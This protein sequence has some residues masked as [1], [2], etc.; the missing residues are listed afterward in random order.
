MIL[1][2]SRDP[3][4]R[5]RANRSQVLEAGTRL[6]REDLS[7]D[8]KRFIALLL[9][10]PLFDIVVLVGIS[11]IIGPVA[12]I[13]LVV[14]TALIGMLLVRAEGRH[15]L[16]RLQ[17]KLQNGEVPDDELIDG[18]LLIASGAFF[19]TPG[20]VTDLLGL[21]LV[22]PPTRYPVRVVLKG[23]V[24]TPALDKKTHGFATGT[25]YNG[26]FPNGP[27]GADPFT[28]SNQPNPNDEVV[29]LDDDG[30]SIDIDDNDEE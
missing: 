18:G 21:I 14:L 23:R 30:F 22:L 28:Q 27:S 4:I 5:S 29:D 3:M 6:R 1:I 19:L 20:V 17:R 25:V 12:T 13:L 10:I 11:S 8:M 16:R 9:L 24:I 15:T 7:T 26:G 2:G